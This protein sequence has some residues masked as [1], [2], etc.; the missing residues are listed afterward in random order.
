MLTGV[1]EKLLSGTLADSDIAALMDQARAT[2]QLLVPVIDE[3]NS[4]F[5]RTSLITRTTEESVEG[6]ADAI[7]SLASATETQASL[8]DDQTELLK[9]QADLDRQIFELTHS[10]AEIR[11]ADLAAMEASLR[12]SQ[13]RVWILQD[14]AEATATAVDA[15]KALQEQKSA[16]DR[17]IFELSHTEAEIR[18]ADLAAM[19]ASLQSLQSH[20]WALQDEAEAATN[21]QAALAQAALERYSLETQLLQLQ[22]DTV[23]LRERE[24]ALIDPTNQALQQ[25]IWRLQDLQDLQES[26]AA[27][28]AAA[29]K[30]MEAATADV[31]D[32][33]SSVTDSFSELSD[34]VTDAARSLDEMG[35]AVA[36]LEEARKAIWTGSANQDFLAQMGLRGSAVDS[37]IRQALTGQDSS[38]I[39]AMGNLPSAISDY[40]SSMQ[41]LVSDPR[42]YYYELARISGDVENLTTTGL[43][44]VRDAINELRD[45]IR[46]AATKDEE[47]QEKQQDILETLEEIL[48]RWNYRWEEEA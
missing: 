3:L 29:S 1:T 8:A 20:V 6:A 40:A 12:P 13:E 15:A 43:S 16:L 14:E 21:A 17:Q 34:T 4:Q 33:I 23:A 2:G 46:S 45:T 36:A 18:A 44:D 24:L 11:A 7:D 5:E 32:S 27:A 19:E 31:S 35:S 39:E 48:R 37:L 9:Q 47:Q 38:R 42:E 26:I 28:T 22:G 25:E 10:L 41:T 30:S